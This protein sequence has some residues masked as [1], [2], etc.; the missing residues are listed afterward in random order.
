MKSRTLLWFTTSILLAA[1]AIP[2]SLAAQGN[3]PNS[4]Y[5]VTDLGTLGGT[6]SQAF[7]INNNGS[8]VGYA[9]LNGD[10]A[11]HAFLWRKGVMT[12]LGTLGGSDTLPYSQALNVNDR[13]EVVGFSETSTSD[14]LGENFCGDSLVCLPFVWRAGVMTPLPTLGGNNGQAVDINNRGQVLGFAEISTP[15]PA[16]PP[17]VLH[18][19]PVIWDRGKAEEL[20]TFPGDTDGIA[21]AIND[22]GQVTLPTG[23]CVF[24]LGP[25]SG[26]DS[27]FRHGTLTDFGTFEG[28]PIAANDINNKGQVVGVTSG[29]PGAETKAVLWQNGMASGLGI[30]PG[31]VLSIGSAISDNGK[32]V[33]QSCDANDNCRGFIWQDGVMTDLNTLVPPDSALDFPDP[34]GINSRGEIVGLGVQKS[35]GE[36]H[37]FLLTPSN[38]DFAGESASLA[39]QGRTGERRTVVLPERI[40]VLRQRRG[41]GRLLGP[42]VRPS[43]N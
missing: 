5:T 43:M 16:C 38:G 32:V 25:P 4:R 23:D 40:R 12:D 11:L 18:V 22:A 41:F 21:G 6:F 33:G 27:L 29:P 19:E 35:T 36:L 42:A 7:G 15:N 9:T 20:P 10:T 26:H 34:T 24:S 3:K 17:Q 14:P 39:A 2:A 13:D 31:D 37:A 8:V 1:L 28:I 30:L